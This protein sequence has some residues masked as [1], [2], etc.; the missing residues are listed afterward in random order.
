[1]CGRKPLFLSHL[2]DSGT[3]GAGVSESDVRDDLAFQTDEVRRPTSS[4][5]RCAPKSLFFQIFT[6]VNRV[7]MLY[8]LPDGDL[9]RGS[10]ALLG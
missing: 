7:G 10:K 4:K 8:G 1:M 5:S 2:V 6:G 9:A 3:D